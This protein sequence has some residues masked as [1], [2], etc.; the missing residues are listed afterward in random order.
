MASGIRNR[1]LYHGRLRLLHEQP[2]TRNPK[3]SW[4]NSLDYSA[5]YGET[6]GRISQ[7][8]MS[9]E[10]ESQADLSPR[11][12]VY[13]L[14]GAGYD[15]IRKVALRYEVGPGAGWHFLKRTNLTANF[16]LGLDYQA[17]ER[18]TG[19]HREDF[20]FRLAEDMRWQL[21]QRLTLEQRFE[22]FPGV[23]N[24]TRARARFECTL[25]FKLL[26]QLSLNLTLLD[27]YDTQPARDVNENEFKFR[28]SLGVTF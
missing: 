24:L 18:T 11:W 14:T 21:H 10:L 15:E 23:D 6:D 22:Y 7:N 26:Q 19:G 13:G 20:F 3:E 4:R 28:S 27:L 5:E 12:F 25:K 17:E 16:A 8:R 1:Q 2:Y 9:G